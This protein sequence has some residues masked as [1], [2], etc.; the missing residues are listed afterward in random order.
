MPIRNTGAIY[1][2]GK[3]QPF[4]KAV[5]SDGPIVFVS[6]SSGRIPDSSGKEYWPEG[7]TVKSPDIGRQTWDALD[8]IKNNLEEVGSKLENLLG[9]LQFV[10]ADNNLADGERVV[11]ARIEYFKIHAPALVDNPPTTTMV[12]VPSLFYSD[13]KVEI[14]AWGCIPPE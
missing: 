3:F 7:G 4:A 13:M 1:Y 10:R 6:G 14:L 11:T 9:L 2:S 12:S 5:V 8:K